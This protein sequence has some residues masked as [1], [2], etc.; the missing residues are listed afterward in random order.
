MGRQITNSV[1]VA[2]ESLYS[3]FI[4]GEAGIV[5]K[6]DFQKV[7]Y[8]VDWSFLDFVIRRMGFSD[9]C[10][11][12]ICACVNSAHLFYLSEWESKRILQDEEGNQSIGA[13]FL[14]SLDDGRRGPS[15]YAP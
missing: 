3:K 15:S 6:L 12:W 11:S 8:R 2:H 13:R 9:W 4:F 10:Q 5:C 7:D 1:I 14:L